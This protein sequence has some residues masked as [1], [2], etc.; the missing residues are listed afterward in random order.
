MEIKC[1]M[2]TLSKDNAI[3]CEKK[4]EKRREKNKEKREKTV[5]Y[6]KHV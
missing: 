1:S 2:K 4:K 6:R 5:V 3:L